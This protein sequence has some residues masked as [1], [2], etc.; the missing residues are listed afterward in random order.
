MPEDS[1]L[2]IKSSFWWKQDAEFIHYGW[3][4]NTVEIHTIHFFKKKELR[5]KKKDETTFPLKHSKYNTLIYKYQAY[6]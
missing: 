2:T 6:W 1:E 5:I 3:A 4:E